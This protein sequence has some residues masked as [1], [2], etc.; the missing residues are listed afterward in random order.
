MR[1][2]LVVVVIA[3]GGFAAAFVAFGD[4]ARTNCVLDGSSDPAYAVTFDEPVPPGQDLVLEVTRD[5]QP[6]T[7]AWVCASLAP[8][9]SP[10]APVGA[11]GRELGAGRYA[12]PLDLSAPGPWAGTVLVSEDGAAEVAIPV[13]LEVAGSPPPGP[14]P[15][16]GS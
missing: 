10:G 11:E 1:R 6:V 3:L 13:R 4:A 14:E 15:E 16:A 2:L 12:V 7:G 5:G 8:Q 9:D